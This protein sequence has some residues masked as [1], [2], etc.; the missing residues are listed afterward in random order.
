MSPLELWAL[1]GFTEYKVR[2]SLDMRLP[3]VLFCGCNLPLSIGYNC[4][5]HDVAGWNT[6]NSPDAFRHAILHRD[7]RSVD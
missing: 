4:F 5:Y 1:S 3:N 2:A 7:N 6:G